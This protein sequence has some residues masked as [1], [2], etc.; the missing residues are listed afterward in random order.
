MGKRLV[1]E[2]GWL[3]R[4]GM[5]EFYPGDRLQ[6]AESPEE[7]TRRKANGKSYV[8]R[9]FVQSGFAASLIEAHRLLRFLLANPDDEQARESLASSAS[10]MSTAVA[11]QLTRSRDERQNPIKRDYARWPKKAA[12]RHQGHREIETYLAEPAETWA[13]SIKESLEKRD[14]K[15]LEYLADR[16]QWALGKLEEYADAERIQDLSFGKECIRGRWVSVP[17]EVT[18]LE[19][20]HGGK[21]FTEGPA[22][23]GN[24]ADLLGEGGLTKLAKP[25]D[26]AEDRKLD[27]KEGLAK[28][29]RPPDLP[30]NAKLDK[31]TADE[32]MEANGH[33]W[34]T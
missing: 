22:E 10:Y 19:H 20:L 16:I 3:T 26:L 8:D 18:P 30:K 24:A 34:E 13:D 4:A 2:D 25:L 31:L 5:D 1:D 11:W 9:D 14:T 32:W 28:L 7:E 15:R 12:R 33:K 27:E 17:A 6:L 23:I 21:L 29:A